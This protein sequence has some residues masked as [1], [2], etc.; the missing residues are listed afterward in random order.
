[1][2]DEPTYSYKVQLQRGET[3]DRDKHT[4]DVSADTIDE[5]REKVQEAR[6]LMR[7]EI[8]ETRKIQGTPCEEIAD[9]HQTFDDFEEGE[10]A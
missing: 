5:L 10:S 7:Q 1:M 6:N 2:S 3:E 8:A 9:Q 4:C